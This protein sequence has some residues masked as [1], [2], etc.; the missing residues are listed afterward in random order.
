M[1]EIQIKD[2]A[3]RAII[4]IYP[5]ERRE[6]QDVILNIRLFADLRIAAKSDDLRDTVDY[7]SLKKAII[8]LVEASSYKLIEALAGAVARLCLKEKKV[9]RAVVSVDKPGAL[10]FAKSV[11]VILDRNRKA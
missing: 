1:D 2:L 5:E 4:G 11:S 9:K 7:K 3:L 8:A 6:K 10:R